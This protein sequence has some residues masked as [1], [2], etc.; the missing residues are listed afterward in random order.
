MNP[1]LFGQRF[2]LIN[3]RQRESQRKRKTERERG[4]KI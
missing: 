3:N 2:S 4:R 1:L